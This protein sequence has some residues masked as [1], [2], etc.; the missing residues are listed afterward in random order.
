MHHLTNKINFINIDIDKF[1]HNKYDFVISNPP[2]IN[3]FELRRLERSVKHFEPHIALEAGVDGFREIKKLIIKSNKLLKKNGKLI[4]EIGA[5]QKINT[6]KMLY[7]Y[8]FYINK[9]I[10]DLASI[11]RIIVSTKLK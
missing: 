10:K 3:K 4:F 7:K 5:D 8:G 6:E 2:Y 1:N 11:P 9:V